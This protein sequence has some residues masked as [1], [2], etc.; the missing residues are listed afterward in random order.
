[1][2]DTQK[3]DCGEYSDNFVFDGYDSYDGF[4]EGI[5]EGAE[6]LVQCL[7]N[8]TTGSWWIGHSFSWVNIVDQEE[9]RE[10]CPFAR[11]ENGASKAVGASLY[12]RARNDCHVCYSLSLL[13]VAIEVIRLYCFGLEV[14]YSEMADSNSG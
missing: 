3:I 5:L 12:V 13:F 6:D 14:W 9:N 8:V 1:M 11:G 7:S 2:L 4:L 10:H